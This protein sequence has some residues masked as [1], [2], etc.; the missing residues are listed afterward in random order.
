[1][2]RSFIAG[3]WLNKPIGYD[4]FEDCLLHSHCSSGASGQ[5]KNLR[6]YGTVET[7]PPVGLELCVSAQNIFLR[8]RTAQGHSVP[9]AGS[10]Q[11][12]CAPRGVH[13]FFRHYHPE[14]LLSQLPLPAPF[15]TPFS[16][17]SLF[18]IWMTALTTY[19]SE[20]TL[21]GKSFTTTLPYTFLQVSK[22]QCLQ[23]WQFK[24]IICIYLLGRTRSQLQACAIFG[25]GMW[26]LSCATWGLVP[27]PGVEPLHWECRV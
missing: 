20:H 8:K 13:C 22:W 12:P 24:K 18:L 16:S 27:W 17:D 23:Q 2:N 5:G 1:M 14:V 19:A 26:T 25:C 6:T 21:N 3:K 7:Q 4:S 15:P 10:Q 9:A 11:P